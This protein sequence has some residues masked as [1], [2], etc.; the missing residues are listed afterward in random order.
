LHDAQGTIVG[1]IF[2]FILNFSNHKVKIMKTILGGR[3]M[4]LATLMLSSLIA[5][6]TDYYV[7]PTGSDVSG[8][9]T[10]S[11]P[12][13]TVQYAVG[14]ISGQGHTVNVMSG[15][16]IFTSQLNI[17]AGISIVGAGANAT[18]FKF[19]SSMYYSTV[20]DNSHFD[21]MMIRLDTAVN[22]GTQ[23]LRD[24]QVNGDSKQ[25]WGGIYINR[26]SNVEVYNITIKDTYYTGIWLWRMTN[27]SLHDSYF[28]N[29]AWGSTG[30][31]TGAVQ[32]CSLQNVN[33]YNLSVSE[34][35]TNTSLYGYGMKAMIPDTSVTPLNTLNTVNVYNC[36]FTCN[37]LGIWNNGQAPNMAVEF[38]ASK[39]LNCELYGN[40]FNN[41]LSLVNSVSPILTG[42]I[43]VRVHDNKFIKPS[44]TGSENYYALELTENNAE[45]DH[46]HFD[47][48]YYPISLPNNDNVSATGWKIHHNTFTNNHWYFLRAAVDLSNVAFYN[49]TCYINQTDLFFCFAD[50]GSAIVNF[51]IKN[52]IFTSVAGTT[53]FLF[54]ADHGGTLTNVTASYN[55]MDS[56]STEGATSSNNNITSDPKLTASGNQPEPFFDLLSG[57]P[58]IN[59][60]ANVGF[61]VPDG[62]P[63]MGAFEYSSSGGTTS[64]VI[65]FSTQASGYGDLDNSLYTNVAGGVQVTFNQ[66]QRYDGSLWM[67]DADHSS[68]SDNKMG[69]FP[70]NTADIDFSTPV[71][72]P[73][74]WIS[75]MIYGQYGAVITGKRSGT[76]L[77]TKTIPGED[78]GIWVEVTEGTGIQIDQISFSGISSYGI[79]DI[80]IVNASAGGPGARIGNSE[81]NTTTLTKTNQ[82]EKI[83]VYPNPVKAGE[84]LKLILPDGG[85]IELIDMHGKTMRLGEVLEYQPAEITTDGLAGVYLLRLQSRTGLSVVKMIVH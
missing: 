27:S 70:D 51:N 62:L 38:H 32:V 58:C 84:N 13:Q 78:Y 74:L 42:E 56:V 41:N 5:M 15:T 6:A 12:W 30:Y 61:T 48:G 46:N 55:C 68:S 22:T 11:N 83:S 40:T 57:S 66:V 18:I 53:P 10:A 8:S 31:Q 75:T 50:S 45:I 43:S 16:Y 34:G 25:V 35:I 80:T 82:S 47:G 1:L 29:C 60:G 9:G 24:F 7:S 49:N 77:W 28:E 85:R 4:L 14:H 3:V 17:P 67:G 33:L 72:V 44:G 26:R 81:K 71:E 21:K 19:A 23:V 79:D 36:V 59:A 2:F 76:A 54:Y 64:Q 63:D 37:P 69:F 39:L 20:D 65:D 52:N 73:S